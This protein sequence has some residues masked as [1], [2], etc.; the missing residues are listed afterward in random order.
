[1]RNRPFEADLAKIPQT[2]LEKLAL[3]LIDNCTRFP[4]FSAWL[5]EEVIGYERS[6]RIDGRAQRRMHRVPEWDGRDLAE[7]L[8]AS[9]EI[10]YAENI[11]TEAGELLD[12]VAI[13]VAA[14]AAARLEEQ[15]P[16]SI[17]RN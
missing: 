3:W 2:D 14:L 10:S 9:L 13:A 5:A 12:S 15:S 7:A 6:R 4:R 11:S 1:M 16:R 8:R 17:E